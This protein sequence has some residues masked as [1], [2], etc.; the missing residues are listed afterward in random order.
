MVTP[1]RDDDHAFAALKVLSTPDTLLTLALGGDHMKEGIEAIKTAL[2]NKVLRPHYEW[3]E[4]KRV[5]RRF[6]KR[7]GDL[8]KASRLLDSNTVM[9]PAEMKRLD[10]LITDSNRKKSDKAVQQ[11]RR[12]VR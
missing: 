12:L 7:K 10:E 2:D 6:G 8:G 11:M 3:I 5:G 9:S 1:P 4:A